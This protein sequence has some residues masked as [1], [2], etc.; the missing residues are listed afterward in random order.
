MGPF[1]KT[2]APRGQEA[3]LSVK[4]EN[5][6]RLPSED[7]DAIFRVHS[8]RRDLST[9][10]ELSPTLYFLVNELTCTDSHITSPSR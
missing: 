8:N 7:I 1:E 9:L 3:P 6:V 2:L 4:D 5:G 10:G